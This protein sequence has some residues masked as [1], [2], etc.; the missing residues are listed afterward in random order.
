MDIADEMTNRMV[1]SEMS[2]EDA[3]ELPSW[4]EVTAGSRTRRYKS[5][6]EKDLDVLGLRVIEPINYRLAAAVDYSNYRLLKKS[7][8]MTTM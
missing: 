1:Y 2:E 8:A 6:P 3:A 7:S 5:K 4:N